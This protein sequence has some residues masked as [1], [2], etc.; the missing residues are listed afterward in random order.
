MPRRR[1][2][3]FLLKRFCCS[4]I[5]V[6]GATAAGLFG[7]PSSPEA[8][9]PTTIEPAPEARP[10]YIP[11]TQRERN[12]AYIKRLISP[13]VLLRS[14][15]G[16]GF[17]QLRD[18]P[19]EWGEGAEG[20]GRRFASA[21]AEHLVRETLLFGS[22]SALHEDNRYI[23]SSETR[24]GKR[25]KYALESSILARHD[26]GTQHFS[27]SKIGSYMGAS[28]IS[29]TWQPPSSGSL[30][31]AGADFCVS[32]GVS[33]GFDVAREFL[34]DLFHRKRGSRAF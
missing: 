27:F 1:V 15:T 29:R 24:F 10:A 33:A 34:P 32:M 30:A 28:L 2:G 22:S 9:S 18:F 5:V 12:H 4:Y 6:L 13:E 26:D 14:A 20:F 31:Y 17:G 21:Y 8:A 23:P 19:P 3:G 16:A 11:L 25:L 7:Q